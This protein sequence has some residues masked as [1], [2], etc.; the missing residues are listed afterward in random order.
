ML[1]RLMRDHKHIAILL[2]I[3]SNKLTRLADG[4][5]V[6]FNLVRDIVEYMQGYAEHS[7]HPLEDIIFD[8]YS[9]KAGLAN[10]GQLYNEHH[11]LAEA[12]GSLI[13]SLNMILSDVVISR[14]K[15]IKDLRDYIQ[16]QQLHMEYEEREVFP[17][18]VQTFD[19]NDWDRVAVLCQQRLVD[20]PLFN[21]NDKSM[22]E[23][24]RAYIEKAETTV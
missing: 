18:F 16:L 17:M 15:L 13:Y 22:F 14:E 20:D 5:G 8:Y 21:D 10:C 12:S 23:E 3:L 9:N 1:Q 6:N 4:N 2:N 19:D 24:L 7:H 11:R